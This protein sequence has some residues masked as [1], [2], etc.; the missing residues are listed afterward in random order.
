MTCGQHMMKK[1]P[2][3]Y[4]PRA[5]NW[6]TIVLRSVQPTGSDGALN[7]RA[8]NARLLGLTHSEGAIERRRLKDEGGDGGG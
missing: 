3:G 7:D 2:K 6:H 1:S 8:D 4:A 5:S